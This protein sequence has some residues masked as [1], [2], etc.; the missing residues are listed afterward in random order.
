M[1]WRRVV[2]WL[3]PLLI[4]GV[5]FL[6]SAHGQAPRP[7]ASPE[8]SGRTAAL[9]WAVALLSLIVIMVIV[10]KPSRKAELKRPG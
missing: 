6:P 1:M 4:A 9:P 7:T 8:T 3:A 2:R 5:C 10:C